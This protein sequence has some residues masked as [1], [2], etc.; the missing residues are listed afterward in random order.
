M[1]TPPGFV[2]IESN[3][4]QQTSP[5]A[6]TLL[7][8]D[9]VGRHAATPPWFTHWVPALQRTTAHGSVFATQMPPQSAPPFFGSQSSLGS[10]MHC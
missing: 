6:H 8:Q 10:S 9:S 1:Q 5:G 2:Q 7:P 4:L 3:G